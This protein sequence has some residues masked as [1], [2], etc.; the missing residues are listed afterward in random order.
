[1]GVKDIMPIVKSSI[2]SFDLIDVYE[3]V[4][5]EDHAEDNML[6]SDFDLRCHIPDMTLILIPDMNDIGL[7]PLFIVMDR[8]SEGF[9]EMRNAIIGEFA[10]MWSLRQCD[11]ISN[12]LYDMCKQYPDVYTEDALNAIVDTAASCYRELEPE[13]AEIRQQIPE[14]TQWE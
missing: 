7:D 13:D 8:S 5:V 6:N 4:L 1:M 11:S 2:G 12:R 14:T 9:D 10:L 3:N